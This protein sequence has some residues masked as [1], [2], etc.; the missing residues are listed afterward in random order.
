MARKKPIHFNVGF[1]TLLNRE[2]IPCAEIQLFKTGSFVHWSGVEFEVNEDFMGQMLQNFEAMQE[3][4]KDPDHIV[5]IDYN[6]GSLEYGADACKAG[7]WISKLHTRDDGMYATVEW[8]DDAK[9]Q[10]KK[11][12]FKYISPEFSPEWTD[13]Y[14]E[15]VDGPVLFAAALTNRPFLKG[16]APVSLKDRAGR[17]PKQE[18]NIMK[19]KLC[20]LFSLPPE[21]EEDK[22]VSAAET[23]R[24][25]LTEVEKVLGCK[26]GTL[27]EAVVALKGE[28][29][30]LKANLE[31]TTKD[32]LTFKKEKACEEAT[33]KV[34][35]AMKA[36]KIVP[37][38]KDKWLKLAEK[39]PE[40]FDELVSD[41][42]PAVEFKAKGASPENRPE[43]TGIH[44]EVMRLCDENKVSY[45]EGLKILSKDKP[46]LVEAYINRTRPQ[47]IN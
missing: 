46:K 22:I 4:S 15:D 29:D 36:G 32:L 47:A 34:E 8:T 44:E 7:G 18:E 25:A 39:D 41:L 21:A 6:H 45:E 24:L 23:S 5:P 33:R 17:K 27:K 14:G 12:E 1:Q 43:P 37:A 31:A 26:E 28:K 10:I 40:S 13:E 3:Q 11:Q 20:K 42:A 35:A 9:E 19:E 2:G 16:M 38:A 30:Q